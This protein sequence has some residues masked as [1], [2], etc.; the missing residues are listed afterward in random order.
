[1]TTRLTVYTASPYDVVIGHGVTDDV[2]HVV[3]PEARRVAVIHPPT[4]RDRAMHLHGGLADLEVTLVEV[5]D[6]RRPRRSRS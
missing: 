4:L 1:M 2:R 5:P 6:V 3:G